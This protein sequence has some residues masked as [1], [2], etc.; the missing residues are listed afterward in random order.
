[1]RL[2]K[3]LSQFALFLSVTL[4]ACVASYASDSIESADESPLKVSRTEIRDRVQIVEISKIEEMIPYFPDDEATLLA[5]DWD[6]C[7]S[8]TEG[9]HD[10][11]DEEGLKKVFATVAEKKAKA[12]V[13]T[14]R[15]QGL[16]VRRD[17]QRFKGD[18]VRRMDLQRDFKVCADAMEAAIGV[19]LNACGALKSDGLGCLGELEFNTPVPPVQGR[20]LKTV[21]KGNLVFAGTGLPDL[22]VKAAA[23]GH[24]IDFDLL[25]MKPKTVL[26]VD[27]EWYNV[28]SFAERFESKEYGRTETVVAFYYPN[29]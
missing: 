4:T 21:V 20:G 6:Q 5:S 11:R 12:L 26:F 10:L 18:I 22:S 27:N 14:A 1:M 9:G 29:K 23:L 24:L 2:F 8:A 17:V 19:D 15:L 13:L 16:S 28:Q 7:I 3:R 25:V